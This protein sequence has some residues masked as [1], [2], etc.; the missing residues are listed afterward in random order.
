MIFFPSFRL[1]DPNDI[2]NL[3]ACIGGK[4]RQF[5]NIIRLYQGQKTAVISIMEYYKTEI[6][7]NILIYTRAFI[8]M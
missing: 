4:L 1:V 6:I 2:I 7:F 8:P 5:L 3:L